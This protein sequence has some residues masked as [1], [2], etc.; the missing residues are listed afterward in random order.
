MAFPA[1][2]TNIEIPGTKLFKSG[3]VREVFEC[4]DKLLMVAS[5][6]IS[7]F[8]CVLP[9][10]IP[11][12]G[13]VLNQISS[14]WFKKTEDIVQNHM[15]STNVADFPL[16]FSEHKELLEK[17]SMLVRKTEALPV[18][19]VVRGYLIGS[20][21]KEY[22]ADGAVSGVNLRDGYQMADKLDEPIFTPAHK[23]ESGH[24]E[25]ISYEDVIERLGE[26]IAAKLKDVSLKIYT[27]A[28][29]YARER[30]IIIADT[31]FEF[32]IAD[33][34]LVLIDEVLTPDSSRF[35]PA[36]SYKPGQSPFSFDK[37]Y[38]RDYLEGL[39]W[40]KTPPAPELPDEV[41]QKTCEKYVQAYELL[42]GESL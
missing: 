39:D 13:A 21:W 16:P 31:K 3:K 26:D 7:A 40:D 36:D 33:G 34:E 17:R 2:H 29:D 6:R 4:D 9:T 19:C 38:V 14:W 22:C 10:G 42:T 37:Q 18:E 28:A 32:G 24:D 41:A 8:D 5:D 15:I 11:S 12:K 1:A 35:W 23:A 20:G 30:G 25:N 27:F